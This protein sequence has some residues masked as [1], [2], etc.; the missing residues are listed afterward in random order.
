MKQAEKLTH[1]REDKESMINVAD[2]QGI[3]FRLAG[4]WF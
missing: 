2:V 4:E 3:R 1:V